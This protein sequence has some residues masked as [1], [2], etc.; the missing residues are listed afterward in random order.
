MLAEARV[1]FASL[2]DK[3]GT[4]MSILNLGMTAYYLERYDEAHAA[5]TQA[6]ALAREL[7]NRALEGIALN[8]LGAVEREFGN[9]PYAI[10]CMEAGM[11]LDADRPVDA[12]TDWSDLALAHHYAGD[13]P[14]AERCTHEALE[15]LAAA[16]HP[17]PFPE[18]ILWNAAIVLRECD[19]EKSRA[20]LQD[21][22]E[23]LERASGELTPTIRVAYRNLR[24]NR[25]IVAALH[26]DRWPVAPPAGRL[27]D[28][29]ELDLVN[30][31][32]RRQR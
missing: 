17:P 6:L 5:A 22:A 19:P 32:V 9:F 14:S 24:F 8:N 28:A 23:L 27:P 16:P 2:G 25:E 20:V 3:R 7:K 13:A 18:S 1:L 12:I 15:R 30:G 11:S 26:E 31:G 29:S 10:A 4:L 21:A